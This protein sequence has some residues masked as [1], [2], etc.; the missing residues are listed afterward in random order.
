MVPFNDRIREFI[1][2]ELYRAENIA[3]YQKNKS[4]IIP[5]WFKKILCHQL[6]FMH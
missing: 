2:S 5:P 3:D 6:I 1:E 4:L